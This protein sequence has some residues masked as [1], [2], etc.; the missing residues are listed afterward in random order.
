MPREISRLMDRKTFCCLPLGVCFDLSDKKSELI[1]D[2]ENNVLR[3]SPDINSLCSLDFRK[4]HREDSTWLV[5]EEK[6]IQL[7]NY[8]KLE[9]S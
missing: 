8:A 5:P 6:P 9:S 7:G 1:D 2:Y 4:F 3:G